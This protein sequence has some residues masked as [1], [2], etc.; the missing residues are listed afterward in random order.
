MGALR[1]S[2]ALA[3]V[4]RVRHGRFQAAERSVQTAHGMS[5]PRIDTAEA[6]PC[7]AVGSCQRANAGSVTL[8]QS[9]NRAESNSRGG[10]P[11][12]DRPGCDRTESRR[13]MTASVARGPRFARSA[14]ERPGR[15]AAGKHR[16]CTRRCRAP[17]PRAAWIRGR[18]KRRH[19]GRAE[20]RRARSTT[21]EDLPA[22]APHIYC[23]GVPARGR[24]RPP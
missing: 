22:S 13:R 9:V 23:A 15:G 16:R 14:R 8:A 6:I 2:V 17:S 18:G 10:R 3:N 5:S 7:P 4:G 19:D 1:G 20:H 12:R 24:G 21:R 11:W